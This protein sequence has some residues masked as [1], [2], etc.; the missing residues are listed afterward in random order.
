MDLRYHNFAGADLSGAVM[1][2]D[3][4]QAADFTNANLSNVQFGDIINHPTNANFW[5]S[6]KISTNLTNANLT[7]AFF[8]AS[9]LGNA[10]LTG[11]NLR[12]AQMTQLFSVTSVVWSNTT[13]PDG[14]NSDND[15]E[16]CLHHGVE[17]TNT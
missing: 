15:G 2:A 14:T 6:A 1:V 13:C 3:N 10:N 12:G 17:A 11:A 5:G 16:T 4:L 9:N 8:A 7:N